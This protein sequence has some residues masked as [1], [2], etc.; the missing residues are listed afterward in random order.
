MVSTRLLESLAEELPQLGCLC[1]WQCKG[2]SGGL[3]HLPHMYTSLH[4]YSH[5]ET[6]THQPTQGSK[7]SVEDGQGKVFYISKQFWL[8]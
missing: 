2:L 5:A 1:A 6:V 3:P 7:A 4:V 8:T